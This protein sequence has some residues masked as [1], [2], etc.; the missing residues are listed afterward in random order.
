VI[1]STDDEAAAHARFLAVI[2][3][4][5]GGKLVWSDA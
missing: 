3:K 2:R 5:S 1:E 4:A